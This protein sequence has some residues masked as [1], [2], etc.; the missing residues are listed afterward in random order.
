[1]G[2]WDSPFGIEQM[3][4]HFHKLPGN[5][6]NASRNFSFIMWCNLETIFFSSFGHSFN[7]DMQTCNKKAQLRVFNLEQ[8]Y[9]IKIYIPN[10][11]KH[12]IG[13]CYVIYFALLT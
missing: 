2:F 13:L 10:S 8:L 11:L 12:R 3:E 9:F 7:L 5:I 1:M 6:S 4:F